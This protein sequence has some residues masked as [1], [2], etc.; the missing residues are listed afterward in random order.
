MK[1]STIAICLLLVV[2][3]WGLNASEKGSYTPFNYSVSTS[4]TT[5]T[6]F[7]LIKNFEYEVVK[8]ESPNDY[9][10]QLRFT[11]NTSFL[12]NYTSWLATGVDLRTNYFLLPSIES[13]FFIKVSCTKNLYMR[14]G[15]GY[16]SLLSPGATL[17]I[18]TVTPEAE[19]KL[20]LEK[21]GGGSNN[22]YYFMEIGPVFFFEKDIIYDFNNPKGYL[23]V[24]F[25]TRV[26][27]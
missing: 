18:S 7:N 10:E 2:C 19:V 23:G 6:P 1:K 17:H 24:T 22:F 11:F 27:F 20:G 21:L 4:L 13:S 8:M 3:L 15:I 26:T 9:F 25:G 5:C 14:L 16:Y 12:C